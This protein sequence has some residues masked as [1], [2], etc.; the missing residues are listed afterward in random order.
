MNVI[1]AVVVCAE[2]VSPELCAVYLIAYSVLDVAVGSVIDSGC[3]VLGAVGV[4]RRVS[5]LLILEGL[6]AVG[7]V[8]YKYVL[9][10]SVVLE[11]RSYGNV[12]VSVAGSLNS[13]GSCTANISVGVILAVVVIPDFLTVVTYS[14]LASCQGW[15]S[16]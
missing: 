7:G 2:V 6:P 3:P 16:M 10:V 5:E 1:C 4:G 14:A 15:L 9:V 11:N 12:V 13:Y 8:S